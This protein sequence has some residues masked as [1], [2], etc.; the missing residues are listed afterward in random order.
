MGN[1]RSAGHL[2][3]LFTIIIW[4]TT[5]ISTKVLLTDF[6]PVEILFFRFV[7]G[8]AALLLVCPHRM[9]GV[10]CR[11]ELTFALAGLC[12]ICLYYLLENIA[13]TYTMASNVGVIISVAPFFTAIL[14]R[15]F[16]KSEGKLR[17]NFFT[18]FVVAM[19]GVA[20]ISFNGSKL[21]L[22]PMGDLLAVLAAFVWAC[23]HEHLATAAR[24]HSFTAFGKIVY[25]EI[26]LE[27]FAGVTH[28]LNIL[29]LGL[30]GV[31]TRLCHL[32]PCGKGAWCSED[33]HLYLHG[34]CHNGGDLRVGAEGTGD[35]GFRHGD[36]PGGCGAFPFWI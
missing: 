32:E 22:N 20:L 6:R 13:L 17:A 4:G 19:A 18:G 16:L 11:Q 31:R 34:S 12:G 29:Y 27:R 2:A 21:E 7:I 3:A 36:G 8:F 25:H 1:R 5:Y 35:V 24:V 30:G 23:L 26:G 28:L 9:K 14:S 33:Q 10:G 15:L